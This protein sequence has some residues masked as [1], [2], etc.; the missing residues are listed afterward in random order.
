MSRWLNGEISDQ[1]DRMS[2]CSRVERLVVLGE[3]IAVGQVSV[4]LRMQFL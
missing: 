4:V 1:V 3:S 2:L